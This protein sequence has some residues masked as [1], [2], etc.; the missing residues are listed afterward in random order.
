MTRTNGCTEPDHPCPA[1]EKASPVA[2]SR[3][4]RLI[5]GIATT[6]LSRG[7]GV[8]T[9][10]ILIPATLQYLGPALFGLWMAVTAV[11]MMA[12]FADFGLG[13]GLMTKLSRCYSN[14]D[15]DQARRYTSSAYFTM[16][17]IA[18]TA[19]LVLILAADN[20][21]WSQLFNSD[22]RVG[23]ADTRN[24]GLICL[25]AFLV[26]IPLS[27]VIRVQYA[28]QMVGQSNSWQAGGSLASLAATMAAMTSRKSWLAS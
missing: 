20:V 13:N 23:S 4:R 9:P 22:G 3:S 2:P 24:V 27:L 16:G 10:L 21:P 8:L 28:F 6:T 26:N 25:L 1:A 19:C 11:T 7:L 14:G 17:S 18:A 5:S 15:F 12:A